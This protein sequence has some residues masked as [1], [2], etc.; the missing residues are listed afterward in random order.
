MA[1][2]VI[3]GIVKDKKELIY[4]DSK[5]VALLHPSPA[6]NG[7]III[8]PR[9]HFAIMEQVPDFVMNDLFVKANKIST[10][11]FEGIGAE[12]TNIIIRNGM[13]AGQT[14]NH[15]I[16]DI[17][18]RRENDG[19]NFAWATKKLS[20]EE[21]STVEL[22]LKEHASGIGEFENEKQKPLEMEKPEELA[23]DEE[24]YTLKQ[25]RRMP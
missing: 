19:L 8:T 1:E 15:F 17:I 25:L 4:E 7:H 10:A 21:M 5:V 14:Q 16:I 23:E 6:A 24:D 22:K 12:G 20:E 13:A 2:C 9:E 18:P 3:C 11:C